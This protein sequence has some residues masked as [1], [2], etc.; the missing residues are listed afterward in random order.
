VT[1]KYHSQRSE[2]GQ[3]SCAQAARALS[4]TAFPVMLLLGLTAC[5]KTLAFASMAKV[6]GDMKHVVVSNDGDAANALVVAIAYCGG[7]GRSASARGHDRMDYYFDC[8]PKS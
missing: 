3:L 8:V 7:Y 1:E 2:S 5:A 6:N 4:R